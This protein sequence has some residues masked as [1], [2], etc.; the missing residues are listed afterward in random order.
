MM[1]GAEGRAIA[2]LFEVAD[3]LGKTPAQVA[4]AWVLSHPEVTVAIT[5]GDTVAHLED[6]I[7]GVG[8]RLD[9]ALRARL[10]A[11]SENL[12][13]RAIGFK[14][15]VRRKRQDVRVDR[16]NTDDQKIRISTMP[17]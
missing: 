3:E 14:N 9:D 17:G 1:A 6:N 2:T 13:S 10:D 16:A 4:L 11:V 7:G 8:W 12:E 15:R 5:G